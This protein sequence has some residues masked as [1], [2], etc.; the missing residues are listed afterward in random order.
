MKLTL[1]ENKLMKLKKFV[2]IFI[3]TGCGYTNIELLFR[4]Y[5]HPSMIVVGGLC[6]ALIGILSE[7]GLRLKLWQ[8]CCISAFLVLFIEFISGYIL[9]IKFQL[10]VWDY[11]KE[12]MNILGQ[13]CPSFGIAWFFLSII[14]LWLNDYIGYVFFKEEYEGNLFVY[15]KKLITLK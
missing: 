1:K 2:L 7:K 11:S 9:N 6:G 8:K 10:G 3:I 4:G 5:T 13:V 15:I 14:A 12:P